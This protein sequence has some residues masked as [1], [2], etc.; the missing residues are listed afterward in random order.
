MKTVD[1]KFFLD[2]FWTTAWAFLNKLKSNI[3]DFFQLS[4][5][6]SIYLMH[7]LQL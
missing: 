4:V 7:I 5:Y 2:V 1:I 6:F 3:I